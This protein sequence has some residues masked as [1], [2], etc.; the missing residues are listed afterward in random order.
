MERQE[1]TI[2]I[3]VVS[4]EKKGCNDSRDTGDNA[5]TNEETL[6]I[7][8]TVDSINGKPFF[9]LRKTDSSLRPGFPNEQ[10]Y[11]VDPESSN[12]WPR[13]A[14]QNK[15]GMRTVSHKQINCNSPF[16]QRGI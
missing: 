13:C 14:F 9:F 7:V 6:K 3:K 4:A 10:R 16:T 15:T 11:L 5:A 1:T 8:Q 12:E 2:Q